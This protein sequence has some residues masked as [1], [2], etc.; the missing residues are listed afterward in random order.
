[1]AGKA[2]AVAFGL[3]VGLAA[4]PPVWAAPAAT[5]LAERAGGRALVQVSVHDLFDREL[6]RLVQLGLVGRVHVE[7]TLYRRRHLWFDARRATASR[8]AVVTWSRAATSFALD[9][10]R[11][12]D[13]QRLALDTFSLR[14]DDEAIGAG[15][16][17]VEINVKLEVVTARSLGQMAKWLVQDG[18][19]GE[20]ASGL[21]RTLVTYLAADLARTVAGE[22]EVR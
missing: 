12:A 21:S 9:G 4:A 13:P 6:L 22:C 20:G 2:A 16:H 15:A 3:A 18:S 17:Y 14:P 11:I 8:D 10:G 5:C 1:M 19:E 7:L